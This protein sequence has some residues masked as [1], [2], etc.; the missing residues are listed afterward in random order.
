MEN[1]VGKE[2]HLIDQEETLL[3]LLQ[4]FTERKGGDKS[5]GWGGGRENQ[6]AYFCQP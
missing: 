3:S 2:R 4:C 6:Q 5:K 1:A